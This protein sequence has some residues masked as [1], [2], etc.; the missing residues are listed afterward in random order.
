ME[1]CRLQWDLFIE[2]LVKGLKNERRNSDFV[3][4]SLAV[5]GG[6]V[7]HCHKLVLSIA[8]TFFRT[9]LK[10]NSHP[11]PMIFLSDI[12][13]AN[14]IALLDFMYFGE[15]KISSDQFDSFLASAERLGVVGLVK[16][17]AEEYTAQ[18]S[19]RLNVNEMSK[20]VQMV[21]NCP[22][23]SK[24]SRMVQMVQ[25][26]PNGPEWSRKNVEAMERTNL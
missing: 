26:G 6:V 24:L 23:W 22:E 10:E 9:I 8:S 17:A 1:T 16:A 15:V 20:T 5:S 2:N 14:L 12:S 4:I 7:I 21:Q 11:Y 13:T 19:Q 25:N 18:N 3:D